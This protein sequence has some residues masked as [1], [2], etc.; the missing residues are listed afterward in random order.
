MKISDYQICNRCV[1]DTT[2]PNIIFDG[3]GI[4]NHCT[5]W[6][7][8]WENRIDRRPIDE[9]IPIIK[10]RVKG[11]YE[12]VLG[13]SG[14][15]DSSMV[16]YLAQKHGLSVLLVHVDDGWNTEAAAKNVEI[17]SDQTG[18]DFKH[19][20]V[21]DQE[22]NDI[23]LAYLKAGVQGLE[24]T[25][26]HLIVATLHEIM[27]AHNIKTILSGGNWATEG[28]MPAA[29]VYNQ[30]DDKN[31]KSIHKEYGTVALKK[32]KF[33]G[34]LRK[35]WRLTAGGIRSFRLLNHVDYNREQ[36]IKLLQR[37]WG[38]VDYGRKH[39]ENVYT[40]FVE[41]YIFPR[42][43]GFDFRNAYFSPLIL[44][45]QMTREEALK[46]LE[47]PPFT[48]EE[49]SRERQRFIEGFG[50]TEK[51]FEKYMTQPIR[52]HDEFATFKREL[53]LVDFAK[54]VLGR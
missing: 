37:E 20:R 43:F 50:I 16:A 30:H 18:Y 12:A 28:I 51:Q 25:T 34:I 17:I 36:A 13:I 21:D 3:Q 39:Q 49:A 48:E 7:E 4:C 9:I 26:D 2:D 24:A 6:F 5:S 54:S 1:M 38:C 15:I 40:R 19:V 11:R 53:R 8:A 22:F 27:D 42:R 14:G 33:L 23:L 46:Q 44:S 10:Q 32:T 47:K 35:T 45:G 41:A 31:I 52:S 29:W